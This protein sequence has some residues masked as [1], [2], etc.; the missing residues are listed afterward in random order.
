MKTIHPFPA[1]MAPELA[2]RPLDTLPAGARV[3]DPMCGSGTVLRHAVERGLECVGYDLDPLSV[4][5]SE[6]WTTPV[7]PRKLITDAEKV[8]RNAS[9]ITDESVEWPWRDVRTSEFAEYWFAPRQLLDLAKL[10]SVLERTDRE[11]VNHLRVCLSRLVITK[12]R[13][14]SLARDVSHSRPHR[15]ALQ[16]DFDVLKGF[17]SSAALVAARLRPEFISGVATVR[18]GDARLLN[19]IGAYDLVLTSPPYLNAIDY[20]RGHRLALI[21]LGHEV[22]EIRGIRSTSIGSERRGER[23]IAVERFVIRGGDSRIEERQLG[24]VRRYAN[25]MQLVF[26]RL[27][28][29]VNAGGRVIVVIG[30]SFI[31]GA[32]VD[33]AGIIQECAQN[34][35]LAL[36][37]TSRRSIAARRRYLPPPNDHSPLGLRMREETILEFRRL[38]A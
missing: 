19:E 13:G 33:N 32:I 23:E 12:E 3:L 31:R 28:V 26:S 36:E 22:D 30:N 7:D 27:A 29:A 4:L 34:A 5:L 24:W 2:R 14:A 11:T 16:N 35:N 15:V 1:R 10:A 25:D 8:T 6:T 9:S 38:A 20:L 21:W 37:S 17:R 18:L